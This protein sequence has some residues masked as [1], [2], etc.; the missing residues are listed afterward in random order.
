M[1]N[2]EYGN[3]EYGNDDDRT[4]RSGAP[5]DDDSVGTVVRDDV[6]HA[7]TNDGDHTAVDNGPRDG[8]IVSGAGALGPTADAAWTRHPRAHSAPP[9]S[10]IAACVASHAATVFVATAC[11]ARLVWGVPWRAA[12]AIGLLGMLGWTALA[13]Q[14]LGGVWR[15]IATRPA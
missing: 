8:A 1:D 14:E 13:R 9:P 12:L 15:S 4:D 11:A 5:I 2:D 6:V 7:L 10:W 3:D